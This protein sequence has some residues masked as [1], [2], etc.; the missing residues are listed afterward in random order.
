M[1]DADFDKQKSRIEKLIEEWLRPIGL[2]WWRIDFI[3]QRA[4]LPQSDEQKELGSCTVFEVAADWRYLNATIW[5]N[6]P[7]IAKLD[8]ERLEICFVHE[9]QH[10]FV[11]ELRADVPE[12]VVRQMADHEE[13]VCQ[14]LAL[15]FIWV[16]NHTREHAQAQ[17][18]DTS[19]SENVEVQKMPA[20]ARRV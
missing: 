12:P 3:Y 17:I 4:G 11:N 2:G 5:A 14:T 1:N 6:M 9:L 15:A 13:R 20:R 19:K 16:R 10:I 7:E 8:D 18:K